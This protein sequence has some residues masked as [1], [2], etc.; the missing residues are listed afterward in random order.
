MQL[1]T[2]FISLWA[3]LY[4]LSIGFHYLLEYLAKKNNKIR[5]IVPY[6]FSISTAIHEF[7]HHIMAKLTGADARLENIDF[8]KGTYTYFEK[9]KTLLKSILVS[10]APSILGSLLIFEILR[11]IKTSQNY[12]FWL[13]VVLN[14]L[15]LFIFM[16]IPS[17]SADFF[18]I[19]KTF[20]ENPKNFI[21]TI[22]KSSIAILI[23]IYYYE[24]ISRWIPIR[25]PYLELMAFGVLYFCLRVVFLIIPMKLFKKVKKN[26]QKRLI[27]N[28][29][30]VHT[31][32]KIR[33]PKY[34]LQSPTHERNIDKEFSGKGLHAE[35]SKHY[36]EIE[37]LS[38]SLRRAVLIEDQNLSLFLLTHPD[39]ELFYL[40]KGYDKIPNHTNSARDLAKI[41]DYIR[42][43]QIEWEKYK[44]M[45]KIDDKEPIEP[46]LLNE[47]GIY[48]AAINKIAHLNLGSLS[49]P[50][51]ALAELYSADFA[52]NLQ[53]TS[54]LKLRKI[55][56]T[57]IQGKVDKIAH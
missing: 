39:Q 20:S 41:Y 11:F 19:L 40:H 57:C 47:I 52:S 6:L 7:S 38:E 31:A 37:Q 34:Y 9:D 30:R 46:D 26:N 27:T 3:Y 21:T 13:Y 56:K 5:A 1:F 42:I 8:K 12:P 55:F 49:V 29:P 51:D 35:A 2:Q 50:P 24:I 22:A 18:L 48:I 44:D 33:N 45:K 4:F 15:I 43:K 25:T 23:I 10:L 54:V 17:S 32:L 28:G 36:I 53:Q 14:L 16:G